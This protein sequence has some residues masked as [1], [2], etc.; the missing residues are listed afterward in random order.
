MSTGYMFGIYK[1]KFHSY[2]IW[3]APNMSR[4][5]GRTPCPNCI[6]T[7]PTSELDLGVIAHILRTVLLTNRLSPAGA[8]NEERLIDERRY[9][10]KI[11]RKLTQ[12]SYPNMI[13][14]G[15]SKCQSGKPLGA[16]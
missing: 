10:E 13:P 3:A 12:E 1:P 8:L 16:W 9:G 4:L 2:D 15:S 14:I 5:I 6:S 7:V 11:N